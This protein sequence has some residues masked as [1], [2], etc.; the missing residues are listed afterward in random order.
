MKLA[1]VRAAKRSEH[2]NEPGTSSM[3]STAAT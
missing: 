1:V 2:F 3:S